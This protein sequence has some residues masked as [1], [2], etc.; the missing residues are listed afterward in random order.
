V[1]ALV[2]R[3]VGPRMAWNRMKT[4]LVELALQRGNQHWDDE[5]AVTNG[6]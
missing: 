4:I 6:D 2:W 1:R 3:T 5:G